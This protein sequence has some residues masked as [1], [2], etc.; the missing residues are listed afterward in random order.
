MPRKR[1]VPTLAPAGM[2]GAP[3]DLKP[4]LMSAHPARLNLDDGSAPYRL[5]MRVMMMMV[6][7]VVMMVVMVVEILCQLRAR[8]APRGLPVSGVASQPTRSGSQTV[9]DAA[10]PGFG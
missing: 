2:L 10:A 1:I 6:V 9:W 5:E 3:Y 4:P 7:M 8:L